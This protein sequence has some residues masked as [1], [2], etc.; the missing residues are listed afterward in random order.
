M[1]SESYYSF[2]VFCGDA[3]LCWHFRHKI[4]VVIDFHL[5]SARNWRK[6]HLDFIGRNLRCALCPLWQNYDAALQSREN[7]QCAQRPPVRPQAR[8]Q[9]QGQLLSVGEKVDLNNKKGRDMMIS[10]APANRL[11]ANANVKQRRRIVPTRVPG[12][13]VDED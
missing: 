7:R 8:A 6:R 2:T 11:I 12:S 10:H 3:A 5:P 9:V 4:C 1:Q 13:G